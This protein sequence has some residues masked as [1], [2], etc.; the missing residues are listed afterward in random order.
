MET[1]PILIT[2]HAGTVVK[3]VWDGKN[4]RYGYPFANAGIELSYGAGK[5]LRAFQDSGLLIVVAASHSGVAR[6]YYTEE[7]MH[8]HHAELN[9]I[10]ENEFGVHVMALGLCPHLPDA[11]CE[12]RKPGIGMPIQIQQ[13]LREKEIEIDLARSIGVGDKIEDC[14]MARNFE[15]RTTILIEGGQ[16]TRNRLPKDSPET[17]I[18]GSLIEG[19]YWFRTGKTCLDLV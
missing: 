4:K 5:A 13:Q 18:V 8:Q 19:A 3:E 17:V 7:Q 1:R 6:D 15:I 16:W 2:D 10:L 12:C 11:G 9:Q 14:Q